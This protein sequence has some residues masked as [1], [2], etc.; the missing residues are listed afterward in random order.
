[1]DGKVEIFCT[2]CKSPDIKKI[3]EKEDIEIRGDKITVRVKYWHCNRCEIDWK[4]LGEHDEIEEAFRK[5]RDKYGM[6]QPERIRELRKKYNLTQGELSKI[7]GW[8][9]VTVNRYENGSLQSKSH[10]DILKILEK[11]KMFYDFVKNKKDLL[12]KEEYLNRIS[13]KAA[14][15]MIEDI[16]SASSD[17]FTG[18]LEPSADKIV[19]VIL[20]FCKDGT[21]ITKIN[22]LLFYNDFK[23]FKEYTN[24]MTGLR[25]QHFDYGPVPENYYDLLNALVRLNK[26]YLRELPVGEHIGIEYTSLEE[27]DLSIFCKDEIDTLEEIKR[28]FKHWSSK[29]I[30]EY[31]H[32]EKAYKETK[33]NQFISYLYAK[34]LHI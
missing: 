4:I 13:S 34:D 1:M 26:L 21:L 8:G 12:N 29:E 28:Y 33:K 31:S 19:N 9:A 14:I 10:D 5:Y 23:Y 7:F 18:F 6:L 25:Y 11:P 22:K 24:S 15:P 20:F 2:E 3:V 32:K 17:D 27:P 30:A 16:L